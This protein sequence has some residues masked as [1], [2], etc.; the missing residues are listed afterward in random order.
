MRCNNCGTEQSD[1]ARFCAECGAPLKTP[2]TQPTSVAQQP[3]PSQS[4]PS[5]APPH[6]PQP[7]WGPPQAYGA[8]YDTLRRI[9]AEQ[10]SFTTPAIITL[11]LYLVLWIPGLIAN[12]IYL[13][14]ANNI[15]SVT[16]KAPEG[17]GCLTAMLIVVGV[18]PAFF[19]CMLVAVWIL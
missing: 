15:Q 12:L 8:D 16:G 7:Q 10:K 5:W 17:K 9:S 11:I 18:V 6:P 14:E 3:N 1:F 19:L 13:N 4:A 2:D